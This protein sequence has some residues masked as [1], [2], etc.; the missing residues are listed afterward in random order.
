MGGDLEGAGLSED[1]SLGVV[2]RHGH[3]VQVAGQ[4]AVRSAP[5]P[6]AGRLGQVTCRA[7]PLSTAAEQTRVGDS[8]VTTVLQT[9]ATKRAGK[10]HSP[11]VQSDKRRTMNGQQF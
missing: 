7:V 2:D 1:A 3:D 6:R 9:Q 8:T 10:T 4:E 11:A 5:H